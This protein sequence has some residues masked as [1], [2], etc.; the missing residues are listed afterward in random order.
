[1][2]LT[3]IVKIIHSCDSLEKASYK[4]FGYTNTMSLMKLKPIKEAMLA[5]PE[6]TLEII[7]KE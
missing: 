6:G 2:K 3:T 7:N 1:M 5:D 4:V